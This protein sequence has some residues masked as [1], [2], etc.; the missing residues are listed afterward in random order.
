MVDEAV[1]HGGDGVA[2]DLGLAAEG[3]VA[4]QYVLAEAGGVTPEVEL[5]ETAENPRV[6]VTSVRFRTGSERYLWS[7]TVLAVLEGVLNTQD[8]VAW[9]RL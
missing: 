4:A 9:G 8:L 7:N 2:E 3:L 1:D 5:G 6:F